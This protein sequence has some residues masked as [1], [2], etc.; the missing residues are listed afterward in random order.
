MGF[1]DMLNEALRKE[2]VDQRF[3]LS[4]GIRVLDPIPKSLEESHRFL[5]AMSKALNG[6][7]PIFF[8]PP[9]C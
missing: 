9:G 6:I 2:G 8:T 5:T 7:V 1:W 3:V 4:E